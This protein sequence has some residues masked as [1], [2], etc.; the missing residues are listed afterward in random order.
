MNEKGFVAVFCV[1]A[2]GR[3]CDRYKERFSSCDFLYAEAFD[4][5]VEYVEHLPQ[6]KDRVLLLG[7]NPWF[8]DKLSPLL[9]E[10]ASI[11]E[12]QEL[13]L[14]KLDSK[15]DLIISTGHLQFVADID[16]YMKNLCWALDAGGHIFVSFLGGDSLKELRQALTTAEQ[17]ISGGSRMRVI[18]FLQAKE[19]TAI[20]SA[21]HLKQP[22][23]EKNK[24]KVMYNDMFDLMND[25]KGMYGANILFDREKHLA[26]K[27]LFLEA[28][29]LYEN[30][31]KATDGEGVMATFEIITL[32]G[33]KP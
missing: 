21:C 28:S 14:R 3:N 6:K 23:S 2:Y 7:H 32:R 16:T 8:K 26:S 19:G 20:L 5:V 17:A 18:P 29:K 10:G 31:F 13:P 27:K 22:I 11:Q 9:K 25:I 33:I 24:L 4:S 30:A 1:D 12:Y 15:Y